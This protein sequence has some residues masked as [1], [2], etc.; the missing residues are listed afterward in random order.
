VSQIN[1][2]QADSQLPVVSPACRS[3]FHIVWVLF[4]ISLD[5]MH[6]IHVCRLLGADWLLLWRCQAWE[7]Q[8]MQRQLCAS[9][10]ISDARTASAFLNSHRPVPGC[11]QLP[12]YMQQQG[13]RTAPLQIGRF[14]N[15]VP[16]KKVARHCEF[17]EMFGIL[18]KH[19]VSNDG[20][21]NAWFLS[22]L[23]CLPGNGPLFVCLFIY[24]FTSRSRIFHLYG[25]VTI[26]GEG[27]YT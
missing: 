27:L 8:V 24:G 4:K 9:T 21:E 7:V 6:H 10:I 22:N 5:E 2:P 3:F 12:L 25:D 18:E 19:H 15:A 14:L 17:S 16:Q 23:I 26:A 20:T 13:H 1:L 11:L